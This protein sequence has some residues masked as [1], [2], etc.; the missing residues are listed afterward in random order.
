MGNGVERAGSPRHLLTLRQSTTSYF[1]SG[2][3][4]V[5][6]SPRLQQEGNSRRVEVTLQNRKL[7]RAAAH[8]MNMTGARAPG[9]AQRISARL[10]DTFASAGTA[11]ASAAWSGGRDCPLCSRA[12]SA[13]AACAA[14]WSR[15]CFTFA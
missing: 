14:C 12:A 8:A 4:I 2:I 15:L 5:T 3:F 13:A 7:S 9:S 11:C 10:K 1:P 6:K